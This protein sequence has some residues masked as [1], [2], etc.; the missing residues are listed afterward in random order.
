M[1]KDHYDYI[2]IGAGSAGCVL[3][4]RLSADNSNSVL[5]IEAG[6]SDHSI[7]I[8]M[9]TAFAY[10]MNT[11]KYKFGFESEPEPYLDERGLDCPQGKVLGGTSSINGMVY[12]RGHACDFDEWETLGAKGWSYRDCLPYFIRMETSVGG[13]SEYHGDQGPLGTS[14][15][16]DM[17]NPL[18]SAFVEAGFEAGYPKTAD[19]NG[20]QQEGFGPM[21]MTVRDGVRDST[22][23][24]YLHPAMRRSNLDVVS[25]AK[26]Q[27]IIV[28]GKTAVGVEFQHKKIA[29]VVH[30]DKEVI[31]SAGAIGSPSILQLSGIG[32]AKVLGKAGVKLT[33]DLPGVGENLQ[34][35]LEVYIQY[36][37]K[38]PITLNS[39]LGLI[40]KGLI[41]MRWLLFRDGLGSTNHFESGA[42]IRSQAKQKWPDIQYHFLPAAI[43]YDGGAAVKGHAFQMHVGPN[44]PR[45][46]GRVRIVSADPGI[47]PS[48]LFNYLKE[49]QDI[50]DWRRCVHLTR[51][52]IAQPAMDPYRGDEIQPGTEVQTD[53]EIDAWVRQN[54]E[55]AYHPSCACKMGADD[56]QMAVVDSDCRVRGIQNLRVVD[57]SIFPSI[58]NGNLNAPTIM[59]AERAADIILGRQVLAAADVMPWVDPEWATRQRQNAPVRR[60]GDVDKSR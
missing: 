7:F 37:C 25:H 22:A 27:R 6:G 9:P 52:I 56:D 5:L 35:H 33:H 18:Y 11:E 50:E 34:D 12:I 20:F 41:G 32:P 59:V 13:A 14:S 36:A 30:A 29:H 58:T 49:Q 45:S 19:F 16:N 57:S 44:K 3:A 51:E 10:P 47:R 39:K 26:V 2:I 23:R 4:S 21:H 8:K 15:G 54:V 1:K 24:A 53:D 48:I 46:R 40:S 55:T 38:Q 43:R 28:E 31:L 17:R 60:F 42:F